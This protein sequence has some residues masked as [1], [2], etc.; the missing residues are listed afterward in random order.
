MPKSAEICIVVYDDETW[1]G[2]WVCGMA[3]CAN[4]SGKFVAVA[5]RRAVN[6]ECL[7]CHE[8][9]VVFDTLPCGHSGDNFI[10]WYP[11]CAV[12]KQSMAELRN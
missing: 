1:N 6:L 2:K 12:C 4:C 11:Y 8:F 10:G 7:N 5:P 3:T 9:N